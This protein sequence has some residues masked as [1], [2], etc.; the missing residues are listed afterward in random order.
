M[1]KLVI[2]ILHVIVLVS[3]TKLFWTS[4][5]TRF[6]I[7]NLF[8]R[9]CNAGT[10]CKYYLFSRDVILI[11]QACVPGEPLS[12]PPSGRVRLLDSAQRPLYLE[13]YE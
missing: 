2:F 7:V 11:F 8:F 9:L 10:Y 13:S 12:G 1:V 3:H 5:T 4:I 6:Y